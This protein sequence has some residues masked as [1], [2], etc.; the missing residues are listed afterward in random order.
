MDPVLYIYMTILSLKEILVE[1]KANEIDRYMAEI[2]QYMAEIFQYIA[3]IYHKQPFCGY[4][5]KTH[6]YINVK[7]ENK[8]YNC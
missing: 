6:R 7:T 5:G 1:I 8:K 2:D 3:A 4:A